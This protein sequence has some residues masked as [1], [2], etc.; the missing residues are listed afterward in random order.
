[1]S[2]EDKNVEMTPVQQIVQHV[3]NKEPSQLKG[4]LSKEIASRVMDRIDIK[5]QEI[6]STVFG[7]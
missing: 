3:I 2:E 1:M 5:K 4:I 6:G 7:Q